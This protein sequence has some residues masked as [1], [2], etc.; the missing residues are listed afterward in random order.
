M[1]SLLS[2]QTLLLLFIFFRL[3]KSSIHV[4]LSSTVLKELEIMKY[5]LFKQ[6]FRAVLTNDELHKDN[7]KNW[8]YNMSAFP[9]LL[10]SFSNATNKFQ[11][12]L[13]GSRN[14]PNTKIL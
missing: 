4:R 9:L 14:G 13:R 3:L 2:K 8:T 1:I 7:R 12:I 6:F 11:F 10:Y 5:L